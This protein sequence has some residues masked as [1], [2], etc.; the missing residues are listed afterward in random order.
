MN[1]KATLARVLMGK[2]K[3]T[4]GS[5]F[6]NGVST[7]ISEWVLQLPCAQRRITTEYSSQFQES[8]WLRSP[9]WRRPSWAHSAREP[10]PFCSS[11]ASADL[12]RGWDSRAYWHFALGPPAV[13][14]STPTC[15]RYDQAN[16]FWWTAQACE[17][18]CWACCSPNCP[19][20]WWTDIRT[21]RNVSVVHHRTAQSSLSLE[22]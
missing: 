8:H 1:S 17:H 21:R 10:C 16:N 14:Y 11:A 12:D 22:C 18:W 15:R 5:I 3:E 7:G 6:I 19:H 13:A 2:L 9:R 20:P 4:S